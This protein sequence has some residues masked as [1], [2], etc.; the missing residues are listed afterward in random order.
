MGER[1]CVSILE[2]GG[3]ENYSFSME[4]AREIEGSNAIHCEKREPERERVRGRRRAH[5]LVHAHGLAGE[6]GAQG[7][8]RTCR[9]RHENDRRAYMIYGRNGYNGEK[10]HRE[11]RAAPLSVI[12]KDE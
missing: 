2:E 6:R 8:I 7:G 3:R 1:M 11:G 10:G 4:A 12:S 5:S 9:Y